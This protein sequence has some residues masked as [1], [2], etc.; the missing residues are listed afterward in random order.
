ML[1][2]EQ[3]ATLR[4]IDNSIAFDEDRHGQVTDLVLAGYVQK[5]GDLYELTAHGEKI[6][7]DHGAGLIA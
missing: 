6:L 2:D 1:T 4:D 7:L 3:I 5:N